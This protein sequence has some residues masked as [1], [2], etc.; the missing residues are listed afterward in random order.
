MKILNYLKAL[1]LFILIIIIL[2]TV[3]AYN[4]GSCQINKKYICD[5]NFCLLKEFAIELNENIKNE[6]FIFEI[7]YKLSAM[8][9]SFGKQ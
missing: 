2:L 8:L 4:S 6:S 5:N 9:T 3:Y 7:F 1:S